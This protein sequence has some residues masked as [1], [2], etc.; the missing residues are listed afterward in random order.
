MP[1]KQKSTKNHPQNVNYKSQNR[2]MR[3][4]IHKLKRHIGQCPEDKQAIASYDLITKNKPG[5]KGKKVWVTKFKSDRDSNVK[6]NTLFMYK[7]RK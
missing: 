6:G 2:R 5:V 1:A 7:E 3:N 4:K